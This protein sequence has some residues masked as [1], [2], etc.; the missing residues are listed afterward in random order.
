[1]N[2]FSFISFFLLFFSLRYQTKK[3]K[4]STLSEFC[5]SKKDERKKEKEKVENFVVDID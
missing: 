5:S 3:E 4:N 1:M 2:K